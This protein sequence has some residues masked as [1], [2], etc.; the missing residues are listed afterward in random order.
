MSPPR[1]QG[2][3]ATS[4]F[5]M[6]FYCVARPCLVWF[7]CTGRDCTVFQLMLCHAYCQRGERLWCLVVDTDLRKDIHVPW[8]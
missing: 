3:T 2:L 8:W 6:L 4:G 7:Y 5:E 1:L